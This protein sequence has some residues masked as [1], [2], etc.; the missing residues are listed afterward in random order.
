MREALRGVPLQPRLRPEGLVTAR[1]SPTTGLR[2][3]DGDPGGIEENF[4]AQFLPAMA[5]D[6][7]PSTAETGGA[8]LF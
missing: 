6:H 7:P 5:A 3:A 4:L 1:I 8:S 2:L